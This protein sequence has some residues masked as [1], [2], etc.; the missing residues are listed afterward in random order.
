MDID[1]I[2]KIIRNIKAPISPTKDDKFVKITFP[3]NPPKLLVKQKC[4]IEQK[5]I[6]NKTELDSLNTLSNLEIFE[7]LKNKT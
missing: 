5:H 4:P 3:K 7:L 6:N 1:G 2:I